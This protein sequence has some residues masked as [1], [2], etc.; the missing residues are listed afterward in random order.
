[1][2]P[3]L[4]L[5]RFEVVPALFA[6]VA[7]AAVLALVTVPGPVGSAVAPPVTPVAVLLLLPGFVVSP[8]ERKRV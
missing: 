5:N 6:E 3:T 1:V 8:A 4:T 7:M 2:V